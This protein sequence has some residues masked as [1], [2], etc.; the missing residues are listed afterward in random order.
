MYEYVNLCTCVPGVVRLVHLLFF[1]SFS[2]NYKHLT[3]NGR[4]CERLE[5]TTYTETLP[6]L[7]AGLERRPLCLFRDRWCRVPLPRIANAAYKQQCEGGQNGILLKN[8]RK[9][10]TSPH[11]PKASTN[12]YRKIMSV[13]RD[14]RPKQEGVPW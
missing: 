10:V 7:V 5:R 4:V 8:H 2:V 13:P 6:R 3:A 9:C 1:S 14:H 11:Q 12:L